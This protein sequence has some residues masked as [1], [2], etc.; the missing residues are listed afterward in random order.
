V[1][2]GEPALVPAQLV[3]LTWQR[4]AEG[5]SRVAYS[6]SS[7][8]ACGATLTEAVLAG[9]LEL[10]ERDA[11]MLT[12][13][14]RLSLPRLDWSGDTALEA[15]DERYLVPTGA[16]RSTVD[17]SLY[18][19]VPTAAAVVEGDGELEP[20]V[21]VGAGSAATI[22]DA[23][24]KAVAEAYAVRSWARTMVRSPETAA[25]PDGPIATFADHIAFY[26]KRENAGAARFLTASDRTTA[27][28]DVSPLVGATPLEQIREIAAKI[29]RHGSSVYAVDVTTPDLADAGL[30]VAKVVVPELCS[31]DVHHDARF[32][33]G[34]RLYSLPAELGLR[35]RAST[36]AEINPDPH[37]FP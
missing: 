6:T 14:N 13:N 16:R 34:T 22:H 21:A 24:T 9:L 27:V 36:Y 37:P 2:D 5:E 23:V 4:L 31:L 26:S 12:W 32:L 11:F 28:E 30:A 15:F 20:A 33:G 10:V 25:T 19:G 35:A 18:L 17:L 8:L 7:G 3:Y 1:P 29:E